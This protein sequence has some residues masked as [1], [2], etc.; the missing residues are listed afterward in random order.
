VIAPSNFF[1][2][3]IENNIF[4]QVYH[5]LMCELF[6]L[7]W[8]KFSR[9]NYVF[10]SIPFKNLFRRHII[11]IL[12]LQQ[13][14][15]KFR[16]YYFFY[17]EWKWNWIYLDIKWYIWRIFY[18]F[19]LMYFDLIYFLHIFQLFLLYFWYCFFGWFLIFLFIYIFQRCYLNFLSF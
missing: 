10:E 11:C 19:V 2:K 7:T 17:F 1:L 14:F 8:F 4:I 6:H 13:I 16:T 9:I 15:Y 12:I 18:F 5:L 3:I